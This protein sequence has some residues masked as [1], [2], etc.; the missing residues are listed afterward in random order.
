MA[1]KPHRRIARETGTNI[2]NFMNEVQERGKIVWYS[3]FGS[4][5][6]LDN[7]AALVTATGNASG[8]I[9][10]GLL[11]EDMVNVD[12]SRYKLNEHKDEVLIGGKVCLLRDGE[13]V[14]NMLV[15]GLT[16][17]AS[18]NVAYMGASGLLTNVAINPLVTPP[19]GRFTS[20]IDE[21]GYAKVQVKLPMI[22][23]ASSS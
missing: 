12:V 22:H 2:D 11:M 21:D 6:S 14:T 17:S 5:Q 7:F 23:A 16:I 3:T 13:V 18:A 9:P 10:A 19:V 1:L 20:G 8:K 4:G 15:P